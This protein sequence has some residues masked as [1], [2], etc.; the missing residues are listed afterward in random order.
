MASNLVTIVKDAELSNIEK[1][2]LKVGDV[3]VLQTADIVPADVK[4]TEAHRLEIDEFEITGEIM[5]VVKMADESDAMIYMG[6]RVVRGTGKGIVVATGKQTEYGKVLRQEGKQSKVY[7]FRLFEKKRFI[8]L[9]LLVP[10]FIIQAIRSDNIFAL[11]AFY[12]LLALALLLLQNDDLIKHY[13]EISETK[14]L[15]NFN[16]QITDAGTLEQMSKADIM[17]FDKTGVLT[18]RHMDV[19]NVHF[20]DGTFN[21]DGLTGINESTFRWFKTAL[22]LC[23]DV[24]FFEKLGQADPIDEALI[25]F[26]IENGVDVRSLIQRY[27]RIYDQPFDPESR[28]MACGFEMEGKKYYFAKGDPQVVLKMCSRY[29]T[30]TGIQKGTGLEFWRSNRL[31]LDSISQNGDIV[32]ALAYSRNPSADY[33][34]LCLLQLENSL[35]AGVGET[36]KSFF[37]KGVRSLLLTGDRVETAVRVAEACGIA[38]DSKACLTGKGME[39][40]DPTEVVRQSDYCSVFAR[41]L[42]SQKGFLIRLLQQKGHRIVMVGDGVNDGIALKV[43]DVGISF[44]KDSSPVARRFAKILVNDL[45]DLVQVMESARRINSR[46]RRSRIVNRSLTILLLFGVYLWAFGPLFTGG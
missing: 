6:S 16:I 35:R 3:V 26:A 33:T 22:A 36:I 24:R 32:I 18:T 43:A 37:E 10:A 30:A 15:E 39:R 40:M 42:P 28:Y 34:F 38:K 27:K 23:N 45:P 31:N 21:T 1:D 13:L 25:S 44:A 12:S 14:R 8:L 17:C 11:V 20:A 29:V 9:G 7:E 2:N 4:L 46:V 5:P 19:K 41:L